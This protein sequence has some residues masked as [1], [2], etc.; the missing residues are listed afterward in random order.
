MPEKN[1]D[2][3]IHKDKL[4]TLEVQT[5]EHSQIQSNNEFNGLKYLEV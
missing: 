2:S 5:N 4:N 1:M 3:N